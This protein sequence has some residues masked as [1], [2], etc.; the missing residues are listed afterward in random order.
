MPAPWMSIFAEALDATLRAHGYSMSDLRREPFDLD[1]QIVDRLEASLHDVKP[2][3]A[4]SRKDLM[5]VTIK[6]KMDEGEQTR[7]SA[8]LLGL[9]TQRFLLDNSL[10]AQRAWEVA[11]EVRD[12][13]V[14]KK[15][16]R[17]DMGDLPLARARRGIPEEKR[18]EASGKGAQGVPGEEVI[19]DEALDAH[20]SGV[21][22]QALLLSWQLDEHHHLQTALHHLE[23][24]E[25]LMRMLSPAT[26]ASD[27]WRYW[28]GET[29]QVLQEVR[30]ALG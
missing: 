23:R 2:L 26:Q 18:G 19:F 7:I 14:R 29:M 6:L 22:H 5:I 9:E 8:A 25:A 21:A 10:P 13:A 1:G 16:E 27:D 12:I 24:A 11:S 4:L 28:Y 3:P 17:G 15:Q 30:D 20:D